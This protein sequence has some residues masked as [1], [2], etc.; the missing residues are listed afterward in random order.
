MKFFIFLLLAIICFSN[1]SVSFAA[2]HKPTAHFKHK[3]HHSHSYHK[4]YFKFKKK[5]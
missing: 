2:Y 5:R 3:S 4:P 1:I